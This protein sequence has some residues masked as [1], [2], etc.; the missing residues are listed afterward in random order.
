MDYKRISKNQISK[1]D[2]ET[3]D[4]EIK[5]LL[6]KKIIEKSKH[7]TGEYISGIFMRQKGDRSVRLILNLKEFKKLRVYIRNS[8]W[9]PL[10]QP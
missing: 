2:W 1:E 3:T 6:E 10:N 9:K 5:S 7:E 8:R 4:E